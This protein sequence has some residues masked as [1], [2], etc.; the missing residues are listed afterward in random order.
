[1][2]FCPVLGFPLLFEW[3]YK[4]NVNVNYTALNYLYMK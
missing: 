4:L 1:M 2:I 3:V